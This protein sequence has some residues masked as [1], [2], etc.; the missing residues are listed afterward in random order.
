MLGHALVV[1]SDAHLGVAPPAVEEALLAFLE[2]VPTLGDCLLVNGDLFDFW[3]SYARVVPRRG[4]HVASALARLRRRLPIVMVGGNHDR[5]GGDFWERDVGI[6]FD[7]HRVTFEIGRRK[8]AAI[9]GDG[10][11]EPGLR[12]RLLHRAINHPVTAVVYRA[13]HPGIGLRLV[14]YLSPRLGDHTPDPARVTAAAARQVEW[15]ARLLE[16]ERDLGLVVMGH[17]H[18]AAVT[19]RAPGRQ[20]LNPGAW[21]DGF[22][23]AVATE[24]G[25]ELRQFSP[26]A[27]PPRAPSG[28]R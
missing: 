3:F 27:P 1:V 4:F 6:R 11:T 22:R 5:W 18:R 17:T 9:H 23:Y 13:I 16:A 25:A 26:A 21:F 2:A 14:D 28:S 15:A 8:V 12:A 20:Y 24:T 10:L 7:P 19:E